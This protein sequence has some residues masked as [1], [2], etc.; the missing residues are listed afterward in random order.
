MA[1]Y[2]LTVDEDQVRGLFTR[3]DALA[4]LVTTI[5]QQILEAQV[6]DQLQ[7]QPY[8]R[9]DERRGYRNGYKPR[10]LTTRVGTLELRVPQVRQGEF[11][12][13]L[14]LRFQRSEQAFLLALME[15]VLQGVS[16]RKVTKITEEL[17]GTEISKSTVSALC[18]RLD[19]VVRGWNERPLGETA[20][21]FLIVDALVVKVRE[22][23]R[24]RARSALIASGVNADGCREILGLLLGDSESEAS[25]GAL[26]AGLKQRGLQGVDLVV[27]DH[28]GGLV[29]AVATPFQGASWQ[30]CQTHFTANIL[31]AAPKEVQRELKSHLRGLLTAATPQAARALLQTVHTTFAERAPKALEILDAGF[32][33]AIAVLALPEPYRVRLRTTDAQEHLNEELRRRERVIRIFP[34]RASA[35]RLLG[36]LLMEWDEQWATGKRY[37]TMD[38]YWQWKHQQ[39]QQERAVAQATEK[40]V[41]LQVP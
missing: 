37:L 39:Q 41:V 1:Q 28:H 38:V 10:S 22:D 27:S 18:G 35:V 21:P 20:Y 14:F 8:E 23:E 12:T 3:E 9:T 19:P 6:T 25:W 17:C 13:D 15:M 26:F 29:P 40:E 24:V 2:Q 36:A 33:D 5:V 7:A 34:N 16:T 32:E 11:S 4:G 31:S 30:R